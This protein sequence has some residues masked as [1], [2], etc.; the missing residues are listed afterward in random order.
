[1][2]RIF[3][4][5]ALASLCVVAHATPLAPTD[6]FNLEYA[7]Q[8]DISNDG[9]KV[10]FVRNRMD[11]KSDRKV[12]NI[13]SVDLATNAMHPVTDGLHMD[14]SPVL[15]PS[16]DRIAFISTRDGSSQIYVKWL[17]TGAVAKISNLTHSPSSLHWSEDGKSLF[18]SQFVSSKQAPPVNVA[19]KPKG[20]EWAKPPVF[21]DDVY[22]R[23]D[24]A[25]YRNRG[26]VIFLKST[27]TAVML[28]S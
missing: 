26:F 24:G 7:N 21:I 18:F 2:K 28:S 16:N 20:A 19:G 11:I 14:Y 5:A 4:G 13:W 17:A 25:G 8:I 9:D 27:P 6:I 3:A 15:S 23:A 22:Y 10:F 1:M 12:G